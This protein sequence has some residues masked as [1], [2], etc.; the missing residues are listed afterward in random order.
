[1]NDV[2]IEEKP[3]SNE[4]IINL[5]IE[6]LGIVIQILRKPTTADLDKSGSITGIEAILLGFALSIDAF[7]AGIG[8]SLLGFSPIVTASIVST[9]SAIFLLFGMKLGNILS[10]FTWLQKLTFL[11]GVLLILIGL[12]KM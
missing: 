4:T 1:V 2:T 5:E 9:T 8:A 3:S 6:V 7:G 11:P 10:N 12:L